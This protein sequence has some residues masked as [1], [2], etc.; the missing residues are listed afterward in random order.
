MMMVFVFALMLSYIWLWKRSFPG[1][2]A[3]FATV[4]TGALVIGHRQRH[5]SLRDVGFRVDTARQAAALLAP[6]VAFV[7]GLV[8][9]IGYALGSL[10][11]PSLAAS[12]QTL[13][14]LMLFGLA[15]QYV[16]LGFFYRR[17]EQIVPSGRSRTLVA[18][19]LFAFFHLPNPFLTAVTCV[20]GFVA[21]TVYRRA[22]N[23]WVNA[24]AHGLIS[25]FLYY[26]LP[27][28][29]TGGLRVGPGY[30]R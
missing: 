18:A 29:L 15:Q 22:P 2:T 8:L 26:S 23:L 11:L 6:L 16:L 28:E 21:G 10:H 14:N 20:A 9:L 5:E 3:V 12:A 1:A 24:V 19:G 13:A 27:P 25:Y 4:L 17:L 30:L 7:A